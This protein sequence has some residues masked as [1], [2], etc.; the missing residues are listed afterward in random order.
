[1]AGGKNTARPIHANPNTMINTE[2]D[3]YAVV[4]GVRT[5]TDSQRTMKEK[6]ENELEWCKSGVDFTHKRKS[7]I[8]RYNIPRSLQHVHNTCGSSCP[9]SRIA[10]PNPPQ[11]NTDD[12]HTASVNTT[13]RRHRVITNHWGSSCS[14]TGGKPKKKKLTKKKEF[15]CDRKWEC[16][17]SG[18]GFFQMTKRN[19][20]K[21]RKRE[22]GEISRQI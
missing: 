22:S 15:L 11:Q 20:G 10:T 6:E 8:D 12:E 2:H 4:V 18:E 1:M 7:G 9:P 5:N 3:L 21:K 17:R 19:V 13:S 14:Q 16:G